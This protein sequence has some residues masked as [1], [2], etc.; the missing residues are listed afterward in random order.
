MLSSHVP[1]RAT[2]RERRHRRVVQLGIAGL[3]VL[4]TSPVFAH[5]LAARADELLAGKDHI[6]FIC[7]IAVHELLTPVHEIFHGLFIS[8]VVYAVWDRT[9]AWWR[10]RASLAALEAR[11]PSAGD[12]FWSAAR[13]ARIEPDRLRVAAMLPVPAFTVGWFRPRIYVS[14]ELASRLATDELDAV[15]MHEAEHLRRR[16]PFQLSLFRLFS[17]VLWWVPALRHLADDVADEAEIRAD[18]AAARGRPLVLASAILSLAEWPGMIAP[19]RAVG[20]GFQRADLLERRIHRLA[21]EET[22][23]GTHLTRRSMIGA[24]MVLMAVWVSGLTMM[25]PMP[26]AMPAMPNASH[27]AY[28]HEMAILHLFCPGFSV[29]SLVGHCPHPAQAAASASA[30]A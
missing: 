7:L 5:H 29:H 10:S 26:S 19:L 13:A 15:L 17:V 16:D 27:C 21:G 14:R 11:A 28:H 22:R 23:I 6:W 12:V 25:H 4:S 2:P 3:L 30:A 18:D 8:G 24:G 20:V 1:P 9:L